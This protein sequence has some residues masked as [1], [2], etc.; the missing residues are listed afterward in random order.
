MASQLKLMRG[1]LVPDNN[2]R[3]GNALWTIN[4]P[5][6]DDWKVVMAFNE[7]LDVDRAHQYGTGT[8]I[9]ID[10]TS[11]GAS[12]PA[13]DDRTTRCIYSAPTPWGVA[14]GLLSGFAQQYDMWVGWL[15]RGRSASTECMRYG[16]DLLD[17]N[18]TLLAALT[19][20]TAT[21]TTSW[22]LNQVFDNVSVVTNT[23][24][25]YRL[26]AQFKEASGTNKKVYIDW[27][28][29][30]VH[31][32]ALAFTSFWY[33]PDVIHTLRN[34][35]NTYGNVLGIAHTRRVDEGGQAGTSLDM[36]VEDITDADKQILM[37]VWRWCNGAAGEYADNAYSNHGS[38]Q[39]ALFV[40]DKLGI[41]PAFYCWMS[42]PSLRQTT[43]GYADTSPR[44][45][46]NF[47]LTEALS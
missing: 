33:N 1:V 35:V 42:E 11:F 8:G 12:Y 13:A 31:P 21:L 29:L 37:D 26:W 15:I 22:V 18:G 43:G 25:S 41:K 16:I 44:W 28:G 14:C 6:A 39:P 34:I 19:S 5:A 2:F 32:E 46:G 23:C 24:K 45:A 9:Y 30:A 36:V 17:E 3:C 47:T 10:T 4:M 7:S 27:C 38:P 40:M 20:G